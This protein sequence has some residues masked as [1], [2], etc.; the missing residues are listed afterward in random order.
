MDS[1][2]WPL[3]I[4]C[5][6]LAIVF[7]AKNN[8]SDSQCKHIDLKYLALRELIKENKMVISTKF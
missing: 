4:Y 3:K 2:T 5:D 8:K 7:M 1:I 6:N